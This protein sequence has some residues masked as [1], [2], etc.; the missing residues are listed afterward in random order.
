MGYEIVEPIPSGIIGRTAPRDF[1]T[2]VLVSEEKEKGQYAQQYDGTIM[3]KGED[4]IIVKIA[5]RP[6]WLEGKFLKFPLADIRIIRTIKEIDLRPRKK[7][8][9]PVGK[10]R[11]IYER[12]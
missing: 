10:R 11:D 3:E 2:F 7:L 8:K 6:A 1:I 9:W 5:Q 4:Y 12:D